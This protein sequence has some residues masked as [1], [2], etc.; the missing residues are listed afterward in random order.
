MNRL[1]N[2]IGFCNLYDDEVLDDLMREIEMK[3]EKLN[4]RI[5]RNE[6]N[7]NSKEILE[8]SKELDRL[9]VECLRM[10]YKLNS[11]IITE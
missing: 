7:I 11:R 5:E 6:D 9:I 10:Q 1:H 3:R 2:K 4:I 8:L